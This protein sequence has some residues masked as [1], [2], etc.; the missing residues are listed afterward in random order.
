[1]SKKRVWAG[2]MVSAAPG[3]LLLFCGVMMMKSPTFVQGV[4]QLGYP[5][6]AATGI[7]IAAFGSAVLYVI[8]RTSVVG[9]ILLT[10]YF[11][12]ATASHVRVGEPIYLPVVVGVLAWV[13]LCFR[14]E[15]VGRAVVGGR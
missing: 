11:G 6:G 7:G 10:A 12:G 1:M 5:A 9:A 2:W 15:R 13:G 4:T 3:L 14:D 8:P